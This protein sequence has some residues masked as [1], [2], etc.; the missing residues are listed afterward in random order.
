VTHSLI[1][2]AALAA[3]AFAAVPAYNAALNAPRHVEGFR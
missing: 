1:T 3:L 2:I